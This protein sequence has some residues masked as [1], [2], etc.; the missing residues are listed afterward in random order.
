MLIAGAGLALGGP[1]VLLAVP[2]ALLPRRSSRLPVVAAGAMVG[3]GLVTLIG[4][5]AEVGD[6][7]GTFSPA[8]QAL[9][10]AAV[11]AVAVALLPDRPVSGAGAGSTPSSRARFGRRPR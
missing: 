10:V 5:G 11:L 8:A 1:L 3:A 4:A 9:A 2:L 6:R 7:T